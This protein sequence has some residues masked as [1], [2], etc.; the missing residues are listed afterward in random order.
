[1]TENAAVQPDEKNVTAAPEV[2]VAEPEAAEPEAEATESEA[3]AEPEAAPAKKCR[4]WV[5]L[6]GSSM[7][8]RVGRGIVADIAHDL[9]SVVGRP[10]ACALLHAPDV[11]ED[12]L[13]ELLRGLSDQGFEVL[14][15]E[16]PSGEK[17]CDL[18]HADA[19][20]A[21]LARMHVTSDDLVV[22]VGHLP[23]L[24]LATMVCRS[25]CGGTSVALVPC[26][27]TSAILAGVTPQG[28][29]VAGVPDMLQMDGSA[30]FEICDLDLMGLDEGTDA[31]REN[32]LYARALMAAT[33]MTDSSKAFETLFDATDGLV[34]G[35]LN[36][37]TEQ[38]TATLRS[39]G[40]V[41]SSTSVAV[42]Q[43]IAYGQTFVAALSGLVSPDVPRSAML[44]DALR[45]CARLSVA[46][47]G[48]SLDDMFTQDELLE[49]LEL[50]SV[51]C[52]VDAD[53]LFEALRAQ[54]FLRTNRFMV[55]E[56]R[57]LGRVRL[58]NVE[59]ATLREHVGAWCAARSQAE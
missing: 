41:V 49:R 55:E 18:A 47:G 6:R 16:L 37:L 36:A 21:E 44:A 34:A 31:A 22:A 9:K 13:R 1:M 48:L 2:E 15:A 53:A 7:D 28:L 45:F 35:D 24:S 51:E 33:A 59:E 8:V 5:T 56:P 32:L 39:R 54:R 19:V 20:A 14:L 10:H 11:S 3:A 27:L 12:A 23:E 38:L 42:R 57:A 4:Q 52:P 30:R 26:D 46:A 43:S 29:T 25:W 40:K 17:N 58:T 50:G